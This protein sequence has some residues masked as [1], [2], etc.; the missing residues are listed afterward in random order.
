RWRWAGR[1]SAETGKCM[2][3][4][5]LAGVCLLTGV[6]VWSAPQPASIDLMTSAIAA[7]G[8]EQAMR[9]LNSPLI[10]GEAKKFGTRRV[11]RGRTPRFLG[12]ANFTL[13]WQ[14]ALG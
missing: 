8:G 10:Q 3:F 5:V 1:R 7:L 2:R 6:G 4:G 12:D 13:S 14:L 11:V 9:R